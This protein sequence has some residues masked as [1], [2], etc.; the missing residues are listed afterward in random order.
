[1]NEADTR[2]LFAQLASTVAHTHSHPELPAPQSSP[3]PG[4]PRRSEME[5]CAYGDFGGNGAGGLG[6][7]RSPT[8][9]S[10]LPLGAPAVCGTPPPG[11][12]RAS[13]RPELVAARNPSI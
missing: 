10:S 11:A 2:R 9:Q 1:M 3:P 5:L 4:A 13:H 12:S 8:A 7:P 6:E